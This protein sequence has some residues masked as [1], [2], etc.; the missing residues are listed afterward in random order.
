MASKIST[1]TRTGLSLAGLGLSPLSVALCCQTRRRNSKRA[2]P[3]RR[4]SRRMGVGGLLRVISSGF[5][6][7]SA[8]GSCRIQ[9]S[10]Y[11]GNYTSNC[12]G[13][14]KDKP[15]QG[16]LA[17]H[18]GALAAARLATRDF[19]AQIVN[20]LQGTTAPRITGVSPMIGTP[21]TPV[22]IFGLNFDP[23]AAQDTVDL[24]ITRAALTSATATELGTSVPA[25]TAS[26]R[27]RVTTAN[28]T[29]LS[30]DDFFV[31]PSP[32]GAGDVAATGRLTFG[33]TSNVAM[34]TAQKIALLVFDGIIGQ[35]IGLKV[36]PGPISGISLYRP[37]QTVLA[38][39]STGI[40]TT[41]MEPRFCPS[42]G[43]INS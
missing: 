42:P 26:G 6:H 4:Y 28:G 32:Y 17:E 41:L 19:V 43:R 2:R 13:I 34:G 15:G 23:V 24:N 30:A 18:E 12:E 31:P 20:E 7:L 27:F 33:A 10:A 25:S 36:V 1:L 37:N 11:H 40:L 14:N 3:I 5:C 39:H 8:A 29:G 22:T 16:T 35:R 21:G 38:T 9:A